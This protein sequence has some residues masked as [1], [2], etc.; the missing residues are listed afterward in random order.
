M[1][2]G[3]KGIWEITKELPRDKN[4]IKFFID[5]GGE[6]HPDKNIQVN[7]LTTAPDK[8]DGAANVKTPL[9]VNKKA[10]SRENAKAILVDNGLYEGKPG[11]WYLRVAGNPQFIQ[12]QYGRVR[13][14]SGVERSLQ[15]LHARFPNLEEKTN[16]PPPSRR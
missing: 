2:R 11:V 12:R 5:Q 8:K 15:R 1:T 4:E 14:Q 16:L 6:W 13:K 10:F 7:N 3:K 9:P